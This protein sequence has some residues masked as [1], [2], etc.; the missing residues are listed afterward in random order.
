MFEGSIPAVIT[1]FDKN[2]EIDFDSLESHIEFLISEGSHGLVSCGTTGESP[3][4][5]HDEHK[6]VTE[7]IINKSKGRV[8]VMAGCGSNSTKE[9]IDFVNHAYKSGAKATLLVTPYYN[10]PTQR[11]LY[12]HFRLIANS[13]PKIP[14]YL[15]NIPGRSVVRLE[16]DTLKK[17]SQISN[18]VGVKDATADLTTPLDVR[19]NCKESFQQLSGEDATFLSFLISGG[20]GCISVT[21]NVVPG[22]IA[23]IYNLWKSKKINEAMS[24]NFKLYPLNNVLFSETSPSP[25]KYA[26]SRMGKCLNNLRKP[27]V[28]IEKDTEK[29]IDI[30]LKDLNLI[31]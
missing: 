26:L 27:M 12:E 7:F 23:N 17:L 3:T 15:Y 20:V 13:C 5:D 4:L 10:K 30:T 19:T 16:I 2:E 6:I 11:G 24:L 28:S 31:K 8:P 18:I 1:P 9:S 29:K 22:M 14:N 21:A 25:V